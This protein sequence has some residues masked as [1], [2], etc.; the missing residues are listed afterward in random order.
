MIRR[1]TALKEPL[2]SANSLSNRIFLLALA[3]IFFLTLF[4]FR[5]ALQTKLLPGSSPFLLGT[6]D[7]PYRAMDIFLNIL[8]FVPFGFGLSEKL[9][10]KGWSWKGAFFTTWI[11]GAFISYSIEFL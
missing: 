2:S 11:A 1:S 8:L 7:K 4:P 6:G 3:G 10:E 5:F 9:R